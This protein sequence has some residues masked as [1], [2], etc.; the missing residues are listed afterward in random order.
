MGTRARDPIFQS[1][2]FLV[3]AW[4]YTRV[5]ARASCFRVGNVGNVGNVSVFNWLRVGK[6]LG[7]VGNV[8][9]IQRFRWISSGLAPGFRPG[10]LGRALAGRP[11]ERLA[12]LL[13]ELEQVDHGRPPWCTLKVF[14]SGS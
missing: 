9:E 7:L 2:H 11:F 1:R 10:L 13:N 5:R 12:F 4:I 3:C 6:A 14:A 8:L